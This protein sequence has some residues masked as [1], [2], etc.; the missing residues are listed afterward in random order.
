MPRSPTLLFEPTVAYSFVPSGLAIRLFV[1]WWLIGPAGRSTSFVP[2][3]SMRVSTP[4][5]GKRTI[6]FELAT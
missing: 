4:S 1:Q 6:A 3:A 2:A 5:Y